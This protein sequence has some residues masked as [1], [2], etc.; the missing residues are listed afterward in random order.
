MTSRG[1]RSRSS[2]AANSTAEEQPSDKGNGPVRVPV[3]VRRA[4]AL[5]IQAWRRPAGSARPPGRAGKPWPPPL[6]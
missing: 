4:A 5:E 2:S 6:G 1:T 3:H